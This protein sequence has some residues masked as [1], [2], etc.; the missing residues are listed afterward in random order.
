L[1]IVGES[2]C[3]KSTL[4]RLTVRLLEPSGGRVLFKGEDI[5]AVKDIKSLRKKAQIIFQDPFSS[6]DP[7]MTVG[8]SIAEPLIVH[9]ICGDKNATRKRVAELMDS[10]GLEWRLADAYPHELDGGRCQ[11]T[12]IARALAPEPELLVCD[13]PVSALDVSIQ[14]QI[15]NLLKDL[16]ENRA[17][18]CIFISHDLSAVRHM[19]DDIMVMYLGCAMESCKEPELFEN[20]LHPYT[21]ALFSAVL[22]PFV[23]RRGERVL[24]RGEVTS[25]IGLGPGCRF[26]PRCESG[27]EAC[28][29]ETPVLREVS[30][31]HSVAC[32]LI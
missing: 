24:L 11:R 8:E 5:A 9:K 25:P 31:G 28:A 16:Q 20:P 22:P 2:G 13:E 27:Q 1:G 30:K 18:T 14:A 10:V 12:G 23:Q 4:G 7:R 15:L 3:G 29:S 19:A 17:L 6:L 21:Q 32:H 26:L